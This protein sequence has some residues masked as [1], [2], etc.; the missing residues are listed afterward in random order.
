MKGLGARLLVTAVAVA[1]AGIPT[2]IYLLAS[3]LLSPTGFWQ[4]LVM[5]GLGLYFLGGVQI[6]LGIILLI[7]LFKVW[8]DV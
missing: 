3:S 7:V 1:I 5:M 4:R 8:I 6:I 2:W